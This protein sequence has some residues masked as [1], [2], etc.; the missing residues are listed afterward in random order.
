MVH[1]VQII[2]QVRE[3][4][5]LCEAV[6]RNDVDGRDVE[7]ELEL[8]SPPAPA[9]RVDEVVLMLQI[10]LVCRGIRAECSHA[11]NRDGWPQRA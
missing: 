9:E 11:R 6:F 10:L 3:G 5:R 1:S 8:M 2:V 4:E 7:S